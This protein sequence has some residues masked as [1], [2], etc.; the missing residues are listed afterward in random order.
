M[1]IG[2]DV[3]LSILKKDNKK[4]TYRSKIINIS[5]ENL[6]INEPVHL[7]TKRTKS[8]LRINSPIYITYQDNQN[9]Y[10]F[11]TYLKKRKLTQIP[12]YVLHLPDKTEHKRIQRRKH[13]RIN[14][15]VDVAVHCPEKFFSPFTTVTKDI[16]GGGVSIY[17]H[18]QELHRSPYVNLTLVLPFDSEE[19]YYVFTQ[20]K[21]IRY[22][23]KDNES[24]LSSFQFVN[25][26]EK[27]QQRIINFCFQK[28]RKQR[29][30]DTFLENK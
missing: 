29:K 12:T 11:K 2:Q 3:H 26:D 14:V 18:G 17:S 5:H 10:Q 20:A 9:I 23:L 27:D 21:F 1:K 6:Y 30:Q 13:V 22:K 4:E 16:S 25:I 19:F 7:K 28:E 15:D 8:L 24:H